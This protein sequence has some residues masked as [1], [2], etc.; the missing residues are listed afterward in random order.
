VSIPPICRVL[1]G[2][3]VASCQAPDEDIFRNPESMARF[4]QAAL[5]GGA[6]G[7]RANGPDDI[8]AIRKVT[9]APIIGIQ[10]AVH[11]DGRVLIT[12]SFQEAQALVE[13]GA[14]MVALDATI[15]GQSY[16]ALER[17][18]QIRNDLG[19][20]VLADIATVEEALAAADAGADFVLSTLRGYTAQTSHVADFEPGF[21]Q[22][23]AQASPA[24][25]I[26]EG[27]IH[28]PDQARQAIAAGA[29]SVVVGTAITRPREIARG[30]S[31]AIE[32]QYAMEHSKQVFVGI[33]L[34]GT[35][36]KFGLVSKKEGLVFKTHI[37]TPASSGRQALVGHL[38]RVAQWSLR[39][40]DEMGYSVAGLGVATA[41]WVDANT[42][43]VAY[44]TENLP[45]WTGTPIADIMR[46]D[47]RIPVAVENDANALAVAEKHFGA[48]RQF[49]DFVCITLGTGVGGGCYVR[50][51]LNRGA[52][53]FANAVGHLKIVPNGLLCS[54]GQ[55]G[56]LEAYCNAD[57][58]LRYAGDGFSTAEEV[59]RSANS[60][61]I[62]ATRALR[63]FGEYLAQGCALLL[64]LLDPE[65]LIFSGG[66]A[67]NN[68]LLYEILQ[69]HLAVATSAWAARRL[70]ILPSPLGYHGGVLGAAAVAMEHIYRG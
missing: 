58:L 48:G 4:A 64:H 35:N 26:A 40:A 8:R 5:A 38:K 65:A 68:P 52:H 59:I 21:V 20:P 61:A 49:R 14:S 15:R 33:D 36:T 13:A 3:L 55:H 43:R 62:A 54:C 66:L 25:V 42:G 60:E 44:A 12:S 47:I 37:A 2:R 19:V 41:G 22:L 10:K 29:F 27:H 7:I 67:Q 45:G 50:G 31:R 1:E 24:P 70:Q 17:I 23:L 57:A 39:R 9:D 56:C 16:G 32:K 46:K 69:E 18:R 63:T 53:F 6:A 11:S 34:G 51:D 30:F 28:S